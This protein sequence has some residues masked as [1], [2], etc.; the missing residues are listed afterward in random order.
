[1]N[2]TPNK[3][4][5]NLFQH[6][7]WNQIQSCVYKHDASDHKRSQERVHAMVARCLMLFKLAFSLPI[8]FSTS[9][10]GSVIEMKPTDPV[11]VDTTVSLKA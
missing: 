9:L 11:P 1:M 6:A 7:L 3:L 8:A 2:I 5:K 10:K 4:Q